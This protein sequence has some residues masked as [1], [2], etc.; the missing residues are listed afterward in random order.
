MS[1]N[2]VTVSKQDV[3]R[4]LRALRVYKMGLV[5]NCVKQF[6]SMLEYQNADSL[7]LRLYSITGRKGF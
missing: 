4:I 3:E 5:P 1:V 2:E 7:S 6:E